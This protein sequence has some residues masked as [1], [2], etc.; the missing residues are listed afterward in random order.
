MH[1]RIRARGA[2]RQADAVGAA[3]LSTTTDDNNVSRTRGK[4]GAPTFRGAARY[5]RAV[6]AC[7]IGASCLLAAASSAGPPGVD[8]SRLARLERGVNLSH[9]LWLPA[10]SEEQ[11]RREF[12]SEADLRALR[13]AGL[14]HVRLP[15]EPDL[16]WDPAAHAPRPGR[17]AEITGAISLALGA[18]LAVVVDV[19]PARSEWVRLDADKGRFPELERFWEHLAG[20]LGETDPDRVFL[21]VMNEPHDLDGPAWAS[22]QVA[23]VG[24]IR[25][26]APRHTLIVTGADWSSIDGLVA[27]KPLDDA[28]VVYT[29]HFYEPHHFTHQGATWGFHAWQHMRGLPWPATPDELKAA[30]G[31]QTDPAARD[32]VLW[33]ARE[34]WQAANL[35]SRIGRAAA[36]GKEHGVALYCGEY[37][38][39]RKVADAESRGRWLGDATSA[40]DEFGIGRAM[41]DYCGGFSLATGEPGARVIDPATAGAIGLKP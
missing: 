15:V 24:V 5:A 27:L 3:P 18:D 29:F 33:A 39:Y 4:P 25:P 32:A 19:H 31:R 23:L 36:W 21:E 17:V 8:P 6:F 10:Q 28:N 22:A 26:R 12:I 14:T 20:V 1:R 35:R 40:L 16:V 13:A 2:H 41:W 30:A 38:V 37:G 7:L 34:P 9:W 11:Q